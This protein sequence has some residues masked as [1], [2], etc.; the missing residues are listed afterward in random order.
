MNNAL[1]NA[2][3]VLQNGVVHRDLKLENVLLDENCNIKVRLAFDLWPKTPNDLFVQGLT[4]TWLQHN[5][6]K[7][8]FWQIA[9]FGLSNLYHKDKLLQTFCGSP[10]YASPEIVN[11]RPYRG[12][13][14]RASEQWQWFKLWLCVCVCRLHFYYR[15]SS[16]VFIHHYQCSPWL[17]N[18]AWTS[19]IAHLI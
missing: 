1:T 14:V 17:L 3:L 8:L 7:P 18:L 9:D 4:S 19:Q 12:P 16:Y 2:V 15:I 11:G 6:T 5:E 10:L 13:E